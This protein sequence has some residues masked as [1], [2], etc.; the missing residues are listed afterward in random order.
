MI[1]TLSQTRVLYPLFTNKQVQHGTK[2]QQFPGYSCYRSVQGTKDTVNDLLTKYPT[3]TRKVVL[4]DYVTAQ[5]KEKLYVLVI[6]NKQF[7]P[8][9]NEEK[10]K[11]FVVSSI[12][13]NELPPAETS[14][15]FAEYL[16]EDRKN[17]DI[18]WI[19]DCK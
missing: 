10:S 3:F 15:R 8:P 19:L 6:T 13:A 14:L 11:M 17:P 9:N 18:K 4:N 1:Y 12:H 5:S 2:Y 16:L 7:T